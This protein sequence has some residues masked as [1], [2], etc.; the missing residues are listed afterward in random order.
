MVLCYA[1]VRALAGMLCVSG[2]NATMVS[3]TV[4]IFLFFVLRDIVWR[5]FKVIVD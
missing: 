5:F 4:K 2:N 3:D 1:C